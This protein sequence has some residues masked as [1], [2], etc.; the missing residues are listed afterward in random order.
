MANDTSQFDVG[1]VAHLARLHLTQTEKQKI[2]AKG[3]MLE[4]DVQEVACTQTDGVFQ[5]RS[6]EDEIAKGYVNSDASF[7]IALHE[8]QTVQGEG[9]VAGGFI[10]EGRFG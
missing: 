7:S 1:Y 4:A 10:L 8:S 6:S 9:T 5:C 3:S 2:S